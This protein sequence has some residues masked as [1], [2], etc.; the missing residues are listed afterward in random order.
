MLQGRVHHG[1]TRLFWFT[2]YSR[3]GQGVMLC[4]IPWQGMLLVRCEQHDRVGQ[5]TSMPCEKGFTDWEN[6]RLGESLDRTKCKTSDFHRKP[7]SLYHHDSF[8]ISGYRVQ[9]VSQIVSKSHT[10]HHIRIKVHHLL[11]AHYGV[12]HYKPLGGIRVKFYA[13]VASIS[14]GSPSFIILAT[15]ILEWSDASLSRTIRRCC[16]RTRTRTLHTQSLSLRSGIGPRHQ[17]YAT[18]SGLT[19]KGRKTDKEA[20]LVSY[21]VAV[22]QYQDISI[23]IP[24]P[25]LLTQLKT[26]WSPKAPSPRP[27]PV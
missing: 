24:T 17:L 9:N 19:S 5:P 21:A 6:G 25:K 27:T 2:A 15:G 7:E 18:L 13:A 16:C 23:K 12:H 10:S 20:A 26:N 1:C 8:W 3:H 22:E 11:H 14:E 4:G